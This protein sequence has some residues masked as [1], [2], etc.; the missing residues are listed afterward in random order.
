M[1]VW[2]YSGMFLLVTG[3]LH[4]VVA[5]FLNYH[6]YWQIIKSRFINAVAGD[7][8]REFSFWFLIC[9]IIIIILGR[10]IHYYIQKEQR[11][12]PLFFGYSLLALSIC[13]CLAQPVSGSW[14]FIPQALIIIFAN[15]RE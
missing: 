14:L 1:K 6:T 5:I 12:A 13:I 9:G 8:A 3:I 11:P 2:K 10:I 4:T 15:R 7:T